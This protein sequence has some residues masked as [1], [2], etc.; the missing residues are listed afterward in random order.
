MWKKEKN[1]LTQFWVIICI[2]S[3]FNFYGKRT[4][5]LL[6]Q[7]W[8]IIYKTSE[9][10]IMRKKHFIGLVFGNNLHNLWIDNLPMSKSIKLRLLTI[11]IR[12]VFSECGNFYPQLF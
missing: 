11:I 7:F 9:F 8:E 3:K 6:A 12:C 5:T 2:N 1:L 10:N 4:E